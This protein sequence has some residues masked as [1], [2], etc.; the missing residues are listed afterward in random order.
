[1]SLA[2]RVRNWPLKRKLT[3]IVVTTTASALLVACA[4]L[5][6]MDAVATRRAGIRDL[7]A[8]AD[9]LS[10]Q[11]A[12][13]VAFRDETSARLILASLDKL[14]DIQGA[15]LRDR[16]GAA[17]AGYR[18]GGAGVPAATRVGTH[19]EGGGV[20]VVKQ[21]L[22]EGREIGSIAVRSSLGTARARLQLGLGVV[23]AILAVSSLVAL[24]LALRMGR[25]IV[26]PVASLSAAM[27]DVT[28]HRRYDTRVAAVSADEIG[29]LVEGFNSMLA[30]IQDRDGALARTASIIEATIDF[31]GISDMEGR[32]LYL[33]KAAQRMCGIPEGEDLRALRIEDF[34]PGD[35]L[36]VLREEGIP[37][38]VRDGVWRGETSLRSRSGRLIPASQVVLCHRAL[39]GRPAYL[40]TI[41]RDMSEVREAQEALR[42]SEE[43]L[44]VA[45][46]MEA[47]GRLA[48][49]I[50][51]DF[52]NLLTVMGG[53]AQLLNM[54]L[55][56]D[57]PLAEHPAAITRAVE[58]A[59]ALTHQ[60][61]AFSR[62]QVI[63]PRIL[64]L[65]AVVRDAERMLRRVIGENV[66]FVTVLG[67]GLLGLRADAGQLDQVL[68]NLVVNARDAM[69]AGGRLT[70]S[71]GT[72]RLDAAEAASMGLGQ[73]GV[74][75]T[76]TAED[77]GA[78][79][80]GPTLAHLFEPFFTTK[81]LGKGTGLGL[82]TIYGI[83]R[84]SG[85]AVSVR[86]QVGVG[87]VF[88][89]LFPAAEGTA[90][91]RPA[92]ASPA[93]PA[94][95]GSETVL[96]VEDEEPVR[97]VL[98]AALE[99]SGYSVLGAGHPDQ[100]LAIA[101]VHPGPLH[102]LI[103]DV[104]M[105]GRSGPDLAREL[106]DLRPGLKV[107]FISGYPENALGPRG[108]LEKAFH[109]LEKP[110]SP[111]RLAAKVRECLDRP[112]TD[113]A[114]NPASRPPAPEGTLP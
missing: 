103:S 41:L 62:R 6:G 25:L 78:G 42:R 106:L 77:T 75:V 100:A 87:T 17:L 99:L 95:R 73:P 4:G 80:D 52:N 26:H 45:Q 58:R 40:S 79:M 72:T 61:L 1:M 3:F 98:Q 29:R 91:P 27:E 92:P 51:H 84:Q 104:V 54:R 107:L 56:A 33:N 24:G 60:L 70:V 110:F 7:E 108:E 74:Y 28:L 97:S 57:D 85:G 113:A 67:P 65:N 11:S 9:V 86:S 20:V 81:A 76:L 13:A 102:L 105:P 89:L 18:R 19:E 93:A 34:H 90:E 69:P 47:L 36:Q 49:G 112:A 16:Q 38:A 43:Q 48:G 44:R 50:A 114:R 109:F 21:V 63:Q 32:I 5:L 88:R 59:G 66:E 35:T 96:L 30:G 10:H 23:L 82:A 22:Q 71:T 2:R 37:T 94:L 83:T 15:V 64:D 55:P 53:H 31:V 12:A 14:P 111:E 8:L 39:D 68:M 101:R 46:K